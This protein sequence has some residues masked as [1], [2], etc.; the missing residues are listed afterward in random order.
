MKEIDFGF[1]P[2]TGP[3]MAKCLCLVLSLSLCLQVLAKER[4][5]SQHPPGAAIASAHRLATEAGHDILAQ[6]GNAFDAAVA[7]S[8][9]LS[10]V[11]PVS[12]GL[13]RWLEHTVHLPPG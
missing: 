4:V 12:S 10:V 1:E 11:E 7:V 5:P 2:S 6:G 8:S 13:R 9:V 3:M